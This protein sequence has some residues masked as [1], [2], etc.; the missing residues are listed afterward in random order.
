MLLQARGRMTARELTRR[1]AVLSH[2]WVAGG[3]AVWSDWERSGGVG[4]R[5]V[6]AAWSAGGQDRG[7]DDSLL[8]R[9]MVTGRACGPVTRRTDSGPKLSYLAR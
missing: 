8:T 3:V 7:A 2:R 1:A 6:H 9:R 5:V 4:G